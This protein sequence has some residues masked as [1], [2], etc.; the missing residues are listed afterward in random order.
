MNGQLDLMGPAMA[1]QKELM[2]VPDFGSNGS[3]DPLAAER[4]A[5]QQ[6]K[7]A[8][9]MVAGAAVQK[10]M[11]NLEKEQEIVM[12]I[13]DMLIDMYAAE[14]MVLRTVRLIEEQGEDA[15]SLYVDMTQSF[16]TD[17]FER[18]FG[19][20]KRALAAFAEGDELRMMM[21]GLKR[22]TKYEIVDTIRARRRIAEKLITENR[23]CY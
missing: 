17:A 6:G 5:L 14:S 8:I 16:M 13:A 1:I 20:G 2:S 21:L 22:F 4:H 18:M 7:K 23:F 3:G 10:Y 15:A 12:C 9:L 19:M 11:Q